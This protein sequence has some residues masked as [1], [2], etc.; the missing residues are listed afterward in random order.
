MHA[1]SRTVVEDRISAM[2]IIF[3]TI[4][5][6]Q[7]YLWWIDVS[8]LPDPHSATLSVLLLKSTGGENKM[9]K[10]MG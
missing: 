6:T 9:K 5:T 2:V 8:W 1:T 4:L 10:L 7:A 3:V